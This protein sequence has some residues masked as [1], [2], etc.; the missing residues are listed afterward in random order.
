MIVWHGPGQVKAS[1]PRES[2]PSAGEKIVDLHEIDFMAS[3]L[4]F[5][6]QNKGGIFVDTYLFNRVHNDPDL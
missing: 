6:H 1:I 4:R 5:E 3:L 2:R